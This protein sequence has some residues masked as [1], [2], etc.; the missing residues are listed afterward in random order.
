M[1]PPAKDCCSIQ[2]SLGFQRAPR[3]RRGRTSPLSIH[4]HTRAS[5]HACTARATHKVAIYRGWVRSPHACVCCVRAQRRAVLMDAT[6]STNKWKFALTT[7][8]VITDAGFGIPVAWIIHSN[9]E[10][11]T[12]QKALD[13]LDKRMGESFQP[14]VMIIDDAVAEIKAIQACAW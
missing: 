14:S 7:L 6:N 12:L 8:L 1:S 4:P 9:N 5:V 2:L 3:A 10:A 11:E 13:A